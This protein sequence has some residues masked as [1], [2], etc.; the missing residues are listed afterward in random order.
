MNWVQINIQVNK[1]FRYE[2]SHICP[3]VE[4]LPC[5]GSFT[6][7]YSPTDAA[8]QFLQKPTPFI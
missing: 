7:L 8:P 6:L 3:M 5:G 1:D 4:V 2:N